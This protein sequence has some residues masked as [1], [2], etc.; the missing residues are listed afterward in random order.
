[1]PTAGDTAIGSAVKTMVETGQFGNI[2][3]GLIDLGQAAIN[4]DKYDLSVPDRR[5][6]DMMPQNQQTPQG[7]PQT[8]PQAQPQ[9]QPQWTPEK[10]VQ[11]LRQK[12]PKIPEDVALV[13]AQLVCT[14]PELLNES[15]ETKFKYIVMIIKGTEQ[16]KDAAIGLH[17]FLI[18]QGKT[19]QAAADYV[20]QNMPDVAAKLK[21]YDYD[22]AMV[23]L[24]RFS[25]CPSLKKYIDFF[26]HPQVGPLVRQFFMELKNP[27]PPPQDP[28]TTDG[29]DL[30]G[31]PDEIIS[32]DDEFNEDEGQVWVAEPPP[33]PQQQSPPQQPPPQ[34]KKSK[35]G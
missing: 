23:E 24:D 21:E 25:G 31:A 29:F 18:K 11:V 22:T 26:K 14:A 35:G 27:A 13:A 19:P 3:G 33:P 16:L 6:E 8:Q 4:K 15:P 28:L 2:V 34:R 17:Q 30:E 1:M 10:Y 12:D 9:A 20:R 32:P 5:G 7:Q